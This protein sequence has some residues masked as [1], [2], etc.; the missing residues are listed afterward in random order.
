MRTFRAKLS[1]LN[2]GMEEFY[3]LPYRADIRSYK[4]EDEE[5]LSY[6]E[7][8]DEGQETVE[9]DLSCMN[10]GLQYLIGNNFW[11]PE[12]HGLRQSDGR[13]ETSSAT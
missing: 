8:I 9:I 4:N 5:R 3:R 2:C 10:C 7:I 11:E 13:S 1:C 12:K 6:Y